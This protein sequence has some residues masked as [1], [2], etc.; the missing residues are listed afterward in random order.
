MQEVG[1]VQL[2]GMLYE[3][4]EYAFSLLFNPYR[5]FLGFAALMV[6]K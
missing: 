2:G 1:V 4:L 5:F 3:P 6:P